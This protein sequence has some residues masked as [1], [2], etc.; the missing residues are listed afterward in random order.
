[1]KKILVIVGS[2][3]KQGNTDQLADAFISGAKAAGHLP[4]IFGP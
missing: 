1:M 3:R 2:G 4:S